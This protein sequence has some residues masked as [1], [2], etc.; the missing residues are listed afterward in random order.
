M[1]SLL[2]SVNSLLTFLLSNSYIES[3]GVR[4]Q[5]N[6][7]EFRNERQ[8]NIFL[9]IDTDVS[10]LPEVDRFFGLDEQEKILLIFNQANL[11]PVTEVWASEN[12]DLHIVFDNKLHLIASGNPE[13]DI[14]TY[15]VWMIGNKIETGLEGGA[16]QIVAKKSDICTTN[17]ILTPHERRRIS[18]FSPSKVP[19]IKGT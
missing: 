1:D 8:E 9:S 7:I 14:E 19:R 15:E 11:K 4:N 6:F 10:L 13:I 5:I 18:D 17:L 2:E 12:S 16:I 3:F